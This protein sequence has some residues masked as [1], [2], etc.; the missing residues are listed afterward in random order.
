MS[1]WIMC[2]NVLPTDKTNTKR[3]AMW[4]GVQ[5]WEI[6]QSCLWNWQFMFRTIHVLITT[7]DLDF[8]HS[9]I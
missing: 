5:I 1:E 9:F 8:I 6:S 7:H 4:E 3:E 2:N